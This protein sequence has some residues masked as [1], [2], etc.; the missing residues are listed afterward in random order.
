MLHDVVLHAGS[1][2]PTYGG[3]ACWK[4]H[5][6]SRMPHRGVRE[7]KICSTISKVPLTK[8]IIILLQ[9]VDTLH[10]KRTNV[11]FTENPPRVL[12]LGVSRTYCNTFCSM[13]GLCVFLTCS[14]PAFWNKPVSAN[15]KCRLAK[16]LWLGI[17]ISFRLQALSGW[18]STSYSPV[19]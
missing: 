4:F 16:K 6:L 13:A 12:V 11:V 7:K 3:Y 10:V 5:S 17:W 9:C 8:C 18:S 19:C 15:L 2:P 14:L 1:P